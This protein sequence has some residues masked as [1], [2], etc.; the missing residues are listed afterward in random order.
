MSAENQFRVKLDKV[1]NRYFELDVEVW[2]LSK[3]YRIDYVLKC[4][5]S[6]LLFG[7]EVKS[8][9]HFNGSRSGK[10]LK[11]AEQYT[12]EAW[13]TK[14]SDIAAILP[15]FI[16]PAISDYYISIH[17]DVGRVPIKQQH[18][19]YYPA[20]HTKD[21]GHQNMNGLIGAAF[22]IGELRNLGYKFGFSFRNNFVWEY[23]FGRKRAG[24][25]RERYNKMLEINQQKQYYEPLI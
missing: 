16:C 24:I 25:D 3:K 14:F 5:T 22:D 15:I 23:H 8:Q 10:Y 21:S 4:K 20:Q 18:Y 17:K 11:Q 12:H 7:L 1:L 2:C 19:E 9:E 13:L 6:G